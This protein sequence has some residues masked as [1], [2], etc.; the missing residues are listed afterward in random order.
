V[1]ARVVVWMAELGFDRFTLHDCV[2]CEKSVGS[3]A[4]LLA[5]AVVRQPSPSQSLGEVSLRALL[6]ESRKNVRG[7]RCITKRTSNWSPNQFN[8]NQAVEHWHEV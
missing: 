3:K 4:F 6:Y 5:L 1:F 8:L 7:V 2:L